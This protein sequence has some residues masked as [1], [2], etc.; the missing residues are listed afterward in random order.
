MVLSWRVMSL[1]YW[2]PSDTSFSTPAPSEF[3]TQI[4]SGSRQRQSTWHY[5]R[6]HIH[7]ALGKI[8]QWWVFVVH[9]VMWLF[10]L[11]Y[12][13]PW[14]WNKRISVYCLCEKQHRQWQFS[15]SW[16]IV[17]VMQIQF[18]WGREGFRG[19]YRHMIV[20][21]SASVLQVQGTSTTT[22][23]RTWTMDAGVPFYCSLD[24]SSIK[25]D[26]LYFGGSCTITDAQRKE[27]L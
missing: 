24:F 1:R 21:C 15:L 16:L 11:I 12:L 18:R 2:F 17:I 22:S 27:R 4:C 9:F 8:T 25:T 3:N 7:A 10:R 20:P 5:A 14:I 13:P 6:N 23:H 19:S 26:L